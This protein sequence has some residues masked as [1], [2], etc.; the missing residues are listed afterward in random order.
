MVRPAE[1]ARLQ[2]MDWTAARSEDMIQAGSQLSA[3][4]LL[5]V[6]TPEAMDVLDSGKAPLHGA[7]LRLVRKDQPKYYFAGR[8]TRTWQ[9]RPVGGEGAQ[10]D[11]VPI[12]AE[13]DCGFPLLLSAWLPEDHPLVGAEDVWVVGFAMMWGRV[14]RPIGPIVKSPRGVVKRIE[15]IRL[16]QL[17]TEVR[18]IVLRV[19]ELSAP[20]EPPQLPTVRRMTRVKYRDFVPDMDGNFREATGITEGLVLGYFLLFIGLITIPIV[21]VVDFI[22]TGVLWEIS[23][24]ALGVLVIGAFSAIMGVAILIYKRMGG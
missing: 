8:V 13:L 3:S 23:R 7:R 4:L 2:T 12:L 6:G 17:R 24:E 10:R 21:I 19:K 15:V 16:T 18:C 20:H 1:W 9:T 5:E 14:F 11:D 22:E